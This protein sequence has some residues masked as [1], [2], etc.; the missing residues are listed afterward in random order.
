MK[1]KPEL[2]VV[3]WAIVSVCVN[4]VVGEMLSQEDGSVTRAELDY[5]Y[6]EFRS[7]L[8]Q[9]FGIPAVDSDGMLVFRTLLDGV[10]RETINDLIRAR[11]PRPDQLS[12]NV[13]GE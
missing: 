13:G 7:L 8:A 10:A 5:Q 3:E 4:I 6:D 2:N 9:E 12:L 1:F 11:R